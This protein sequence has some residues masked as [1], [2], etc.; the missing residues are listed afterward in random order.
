MKKTNKRAMIENNI[1]KRM[2][3]LALATLMPVSFTSCK[4]NKEVTNV[5]ETSTT[6]ASNTS[7]NVF[8]FDADE[9]ILRTAKETYEYPDMDDLNSIIDQIKSIKYISS[10]DEFNEYDVYSKPM[11]EANNILSTNYTV[12]YDKYPINYDW[13]KNGVVDENALYNKIINN[14][15]N[16]QIDNNHYID[17]IA[18]E[19]SVTLKYNINLIKK[20]NPDFKFNLAF[21]NLNNLVVN[22]TTQDDCAA[23]YAPGSNTLC[24][25]INYIDG[26]DSFKNTISHELFHLIFNSCLECDPFYFSG[27]GID[28]T[29]T[30]ENPLAT[31]FLTELTAENFSYAAFNEEPSCLYDEE[32]EKLNYICLCTGKD[33]KY[34]ES[35]VV[36]A[37]IKGI[38]N[39]F[40]P[41]FRSVNYVY[42]ILSSFDNSCGY[43]YFDENWDYTLFQSSSFNFAMFGLLKNAYVKIIKDVKL[44]KINKE[45]AD[46]KINKLKS[47][48]NFSDADDNYLKC[49]N[50]LDNIYENSFSKVK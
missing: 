21:Y 30:L 9:N 42:S 13:Y 24:V 35:C 34:Y 43:G 14:I 19:V 31:D 5:S 10:Y 11:I 6:Y 36:N 8:Y 17:K 40:E 44:G 48:M 47:D 50:E 15:K 3:S 37:D 33:K 18:K 23:F 26:F 7:N 27:C 38:I 2:I 4:N 46:Y 22:T 29:T 39:S 12:D 32:R 1:A 45:E 16:E 28:D 49:V 25:N 41:E 20:V